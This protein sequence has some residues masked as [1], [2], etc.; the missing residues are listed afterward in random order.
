MVSIHF[1]VVAERTGFEPAV[2]FRTRHFQ[3]RTID[4]SDTSPQV[5][6]TNIQIAYLLY[7]MKNEL[8]ILLKRLKSIFSCI[9]L[10]FDYSGYRLSDFSFKSRENDIFP[11]KS[12]RLNSAMIKFIRKCFLFLSRHNFF[13]KIQL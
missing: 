9:A 4:H 6:L 10:F 13:G 7:K 11:L 2:R 8:S 3:C 1:F 12:R 5:D